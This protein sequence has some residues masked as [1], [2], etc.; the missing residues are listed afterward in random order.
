MENGEGGKIYRE[1]L[2]PYTGVIVD[3]EE[4]FMLEELYSDRE[5]TDEEIRSIHKAY[6]RALKVKHS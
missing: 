6:Q 2:N 5:C 1:L 4:Y 3:E